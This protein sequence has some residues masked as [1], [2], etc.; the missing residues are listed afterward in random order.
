MT[1]E[2]KVEKDSWIKKFIVWSDRPT[3]QFL[4]P[5]AFV[6]LFAASFRSYEMG[7]AMVLAMVLHELGHA[8]IMEKNQVGWKVLW[9]FPLGAVVTTRDSIE[10]EKS[11]KLHWYNL[12]FLMLA[13][14]AVNVALMG[15][16]H[17]LLQVSLEEWGSAF[18]AVNG[19]LLALN[20]IPLGKLDAGQHFKLIF[21]SL[22]KQHEVRFML[23]IIT[24]L[25]FGWITLFVLGYGS[26]LFFIFKNIGWFAT[27]LIV[28]VSLF[29]TSFK[30]DEEHSRS[31]LAMNHT[32]VIIATIAYFVL[33]GVSLFLFAGLPVIV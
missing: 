30:D 25:F 23:V 22:A 24:L 21:S 18:V 8:L 2:N 12:S 1:Q 13:G 29:F 15:V 28:V 5:L 20:L 31:P 3:I 10:L 4:S 32:Q 27:S 19:Y 16:G 17:L 14:P 11:N 33:V 26:F 6:L 7:I 9:L